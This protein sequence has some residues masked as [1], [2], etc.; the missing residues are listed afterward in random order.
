MEDAITCFVTHF[1]L[2]VLSVMSFLLV[3]GTLNVVEYLNGRRPRLQTVNLT[4]H[5][6]M[7]RLS[8]QRIR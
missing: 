1:P 4:T 8:L 3:L 6:A 2:S 7:V 5:P